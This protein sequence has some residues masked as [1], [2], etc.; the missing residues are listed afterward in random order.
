MNTTSVLGQHMP[1]AFPQ[2]GGT[3]WN[4]ALQYLNQKEYEQIIDILQKRHKAAKKEGNNAQAG[5]LTAAQQICLGCIQ[6]QAEIEQRRQF[7]TEAIGREKELQR[8]LCALLELVQNSV[9]D[10]ANGTLIHAPP[11][12]RNGETSHHEQRADTESAS[13]WQRIQSFLYATP[14][15]QSSDAKPVPRTEPT[16]VDESTNPTGGNES[17]ANVDIISHDRGAKRPSL[18][19]CCFGQFQVFEDEHLI[20][21]WTNRK[22]KAIFKHLLMQRPKPVVKDVLMELFWPDSSPD[23]AR[24]NLNVAIYSLRRA[25]RNG[26]PDFSHILFQEDCYLINPDIDLWVDVDEF[27]RCIQDAEQLEKQGNIAEAIRCYHRAEALYQ[28]ELFA[29]D[30]YEEWILPERRNLH[31]IYIDV[32]TKLSDYHYSLGD[33]TSCASICQKLLL[34]EPC[35]EETHRRLMTTY[36]RQGHK[37]LALRQYHLCVTHLKEE[38][39]I[40]PLP[41]TTQLYE[42]IRSETCT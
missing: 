28:G 4:T 36:C 14:S 10:D 27:V 32:L 7:L 19:V 8:Q 25:L 30:R 42:Q 21:D 37:H 39:D 31:K 24:N 15:S 22:G 18:S 17:E 16:S 5:L 40:A 2:A 20:D 29:E 38:L 34:V 6:H 1:D 11:A 13:L 3:E 33:Y 35:R 23:A 9:H 26:Y 41:E 12:P